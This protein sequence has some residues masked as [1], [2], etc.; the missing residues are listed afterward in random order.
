MRAVGAIAVD[1]EVIHRAPHAI[2]ALGDVLSFHVDD[3]AELQGAVGDLRNDV[4][5]LAF[6]VGGGIISH[7]VVLVG[8]DKGG[9]RHL[10]EGGGADVIGAVG[11]VLNGLRDVVSLGL[12]SDTAPE[13]EVG[14]AG[15]V[16][17]VEAPC[18]VL[19]G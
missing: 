2:D 10:R 6:H 19:T 17:A 14:R 1:R 4:V 18:A 16:C 9:V 3:D 12:L 7:V 11:Q 13:V 5:V 8:E 15:E